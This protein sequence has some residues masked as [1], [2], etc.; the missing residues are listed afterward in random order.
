[1]AANAI[2]N[3]SLVGLPAPIRRSLEHADIPGR[4]VPE[5][6]SLRQR[7]EILIRD[8]WWPFTASETYTLSPPSFR[9]NAAVRVAGIP[10]ATVHDSLANGRGRMNVRVLGLFSVVD[11]SGP[12]MDQGALMRWLNESM[13]FPHVWAT[14]TI[15]WTPVDNWSAIGRVSVGGLAVEAEFCVDDAGRLIDFHADRYRIDASGAELIRWSTPLA[16]HARFDGVELPT[17]GSATW[18]LDDEVLEY[19]RL[20][21][22]QVHYT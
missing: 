2:T 12:E 3:E 19:I 8:K 6:V 15:A 9:W 5:L 4:P 13:W 11:E 14:G 22:T 1:V 17:R 7:G 18:T 16:G 10:M 21:V 20:E